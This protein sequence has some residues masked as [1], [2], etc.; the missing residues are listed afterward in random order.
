MNVSLGIPGFLDGFTYVSLYSRRV[1]HLRQASLN[2]NAIKVQRHS[3][4]HLEINTYVQV[5]IQ[6][7]SE[8]R[9]PPL[10][11]LPFRFSKSEKSRETQLDL[12]VLRLLGVLIWKDGFSSSL[13]RPVILLLHQ[14]SDSTCHVT[15]KEGVPKVKDVFYPQKMIKK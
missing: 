12:S 11:P 2:T 4:V 3:V 8:F 7:K 9:M 13:H 14:K 1:T 10:L 5:L 6:W 15:G